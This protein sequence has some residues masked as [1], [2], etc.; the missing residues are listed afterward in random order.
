MF[1]QRAAGISAAFLPLSEE[2]ADQENPDLS[3]EKKKRIYIC[4]ALGQDGMILP[5][6]KNV[7]G[8]EHRLLALSLPL[9]SINS[10]RIPT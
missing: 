8:S 2:E 3:Q 7:Q 1:P 6:L 4:P 9:H 5:N 10:E